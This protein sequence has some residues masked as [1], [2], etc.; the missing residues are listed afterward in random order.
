MVLRCRRP[1][2][3]LPVQPPLLRPAELPGRGEPDGQRGGTRPGHPARA[4]HPAGRAVGHLPRR[5]AVRA[6]AHGIRLVLAVP[7]PPRGAPAGR[8]HRRRVH[9]LRAGHGVARQRPPEL[10]RAVPRA[11]HRRPGAAPGRRPPATARRHRARPAGRLA[12]LHRRGGPPADRG[13][14]GRRR[15]RLPRPRRA[16]GAPDAARHRHRRR[17]LPGHRRPAAVLAVRGAA[18]LRRHL[19]PA[20]RQRPRPALRAGHPQHRG[21]PVGLGG[22]CR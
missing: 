22:E 10:R 16:A 19:P 20:G 6:G 7:S 17:R 15:S 3:G 14:P 4:A 12:G 13:R 9:R 21:R 11:A 18:E 5:R 2:P 1:Q 8:R